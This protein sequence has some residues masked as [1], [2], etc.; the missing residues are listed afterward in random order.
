MEEEY[1]PTIIRLILSID[2]ALILLKESLKILHFLTI[3]HNKWR[4]TELIHYET[5]SIAKVTL[6]KKLHQ[7]K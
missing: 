2:L 6:G 4:I 5:D 7:N 1:T 3:P